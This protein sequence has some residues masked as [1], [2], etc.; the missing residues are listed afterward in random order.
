MTDLTQLA[1]ALTN[2]S[3]R[4]ITDSGNS[5]LSPALSPSASPS[6]A[7]DRKTSQDLLSNGRRVTRHQVRL[8]KQCFPFL[9]LPAELRIVVYSFSS[10]FEKLNEFFDKSFARLSANPTSLLSP[11]APHKR[12]PNV[13]LINKQ[14]FREASH[15]LHKQG[16]SFH[17]GLLRHKLSDVISPAILRQVSFLEITDVGHPMIKAKTMVSSWAG[18]MKLLRQLGKLLSTG[19]HNLKKLSIRLDD[20]RLVEHMTQCHD[21]PHKCGFRDQMSEALAALGKARGIDEVTLH[22]LNVHEAAKL[23]RLLQRPMIPFLSLPLELR[24][25]VYKHTGDWSDSSIILGRAVVQWTDQGMPK[26]FP[27]P[28]RTT[29]TV[30]LINKQISAEALDIL[31][32]KP[33]NIVYPQAEFTKDTH[34]PS[35]VAFLSR[36]SIQHAHTITIDMQCWQ[37]SADLEHRIIGFLAT[38]KKLQHFTLKFRDVLKKAFQASNKPSYPDLRV[39]TSLKVLRSVRGLKTVKFEGDLPDVFTTPLVQIMTSPPSVQLQD[40]PKLKALL[41]GGGTEDIDERETPSRR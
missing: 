28:G 19:P 26:R 6:T 8:I 36:K 1:Y 4:R 23:K 30:L 34:I 33:L 29:P 32:K 13:Y 35:I 21:T 39:A 11:L 38:S 12:T 2:F 37:W 40:L 10:D 20:P 17:H 24:Q 41:P 14:I 27:F 7:M 31:Q 18:Y 25:M 3:I 9:C 16:V 15:L 22:G 5:T